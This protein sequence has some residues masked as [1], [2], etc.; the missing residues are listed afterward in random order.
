MGS[1]SFD[2]E[3]IEKVIEMLAREKTLPEKYRDHGL[4]GRFRGYRDCHLRFDIVLIYRISD[5]RLLLVLLDIGS[6][7]EIFRR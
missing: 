6:H 2:R 1:G 4:D 7:S 3:E 5:N